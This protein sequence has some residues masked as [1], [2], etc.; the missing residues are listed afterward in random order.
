MGLY[1]KHSAIHCVESMFENGKTDPLFRFPVLKTEKRIRYFV[2]SFSKTEKRDNGSVIPF[3]RF[4][5]QNEKT[6]KR[7]YG[8][9]IS[10]FRFG[11]LNG[12][13]NGPFVHG[14]SS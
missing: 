1:A 9:V 2:I 11:F 5:F 13:T 6:E 10:F 3:I 14:R 7:N 4:C 8:S 12:K